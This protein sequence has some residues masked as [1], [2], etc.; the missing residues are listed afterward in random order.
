MKKKKSYKLKRII[1]ALSKAAQDI[2]ITIKTVPKKPKVDKRKLEIEKR[3]LER[4]RKVERLRNL[5]KARL[6][7]QYIILLNKKLLYLENTHKSMKRSKKYK[8]SDLNKIEKKINEL[9]KKIKYL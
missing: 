5:E 6:K 1:L 7:R 9:K 3:R 4:Q 8:K 2:P